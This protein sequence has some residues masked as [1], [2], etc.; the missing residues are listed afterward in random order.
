M[1]IINDFQDRRIDILVGTQMVT[2][3]LDFDNVGLVGV[4]NADNMLM[5]PDFRSFEYSFQQLTQVSGRAG[6]KHKRGKV[7]I[8]TSQP[9]HD[10]IR[11]VIAN[12]YFKMYESQMIERINFKY[13]PIYRL[14][15]ISLKHRDYHILN[16]GAKQYADMLR[17]KLGNRVLGPEYP[18]I[19]RIKNMYIKNIMI[20]FEAMASAKYVKDILSEARLNLLQEDLYKS[21]RVQMDVDPV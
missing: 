3:G 6:R 18:H 20:K 17:P 2:K 10:V 1:Q 12:E 8:Q 21:L 19:S 11:N 4:L 15:K 5:F 9:Y 7:I 13:P 14:I 16:D